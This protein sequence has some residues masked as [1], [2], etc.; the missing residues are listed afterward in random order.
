[1][2]K[3][4]ISIFSPVY[5]FIHKTGKVFLAKF[6][7]LFDMMGLFYDVLVGL[8]SL[9]RKHHLSLKQITSQILFTGVDA[10]FIISVI[11]LFCGITLTVQGM[12]NMP[13]IGLGEY[14]ANLMVIAIIRELG[15]FFASLVVIA[16]SGAALATFIGNMRITKE[17]TALEVMGIDKNY[18]IVSPAFLGM[19]MS[20]ICLNI[21][22]D[23][24]A[25]TAGLLIAMV[26]INFPPGIFIKQ[27][28]GAISTTDLIVMIT[29]NICFGSVI[30]IVTCYY[31]FSV[32]NIRTVPRAVY[33][34][35]MGSIVL[36]MLINIC[37]TIG[38]YA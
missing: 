34:A 25:V 16:R 5:R 9:P 24:I 33:K 11:G 6:K 27:L 32:T 38:F 22:F 31:G 36:T 4:E 10:F 15:P 2:S 14:F 28:I 17:I 30:A 1:M 23:I 12:S 37:L 21:Y 29:K 20:L 19:I 3:I 7:I 35:V 8:I 26:T 18:F 13:E